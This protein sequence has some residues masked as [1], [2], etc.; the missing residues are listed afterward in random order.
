M[1]DHAVALHLAEAQTTVARATLSRLPSKDLSG[2]SSSGVDLVLH[3]VLEPLVVGRPEEDLDLHLLAVEA[4]IHDFVA[5]ELVALLVEKLGDLL[6]SVLLSRADS[7]ERRGV[8]LD[9]SEGTDLRGQ[10]LNQVADSHAR[11]NGMRVDD[12]VWRDAF[13]GERQVLLPVGH[14][15]GT[16]L[17]MA[18]GKLVSDLRDSLRPHLDLRKAETRLVDR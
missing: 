13:S 15:A 2:P 5:S 1:R 18:T 6:D 10:T 12:E 7:L 3:H 11:R 8:A 9:A 4:V 17:A 16:L 14:A